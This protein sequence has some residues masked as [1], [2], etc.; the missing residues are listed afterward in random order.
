M[1]TVEVMKTDLPEYENPPVNAVVC[2]IQFK[3]LEGLRIPHFGLFW[4]QC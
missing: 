4:D 2:G 3:T 1:E